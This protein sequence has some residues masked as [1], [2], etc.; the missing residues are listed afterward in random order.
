VDPAERSRVLAQLQRRLQAALQPLLQ[1]MFDALD[2]R[3]FDLAERS[4]VASQ[5]QVFFEG[6]RECRRKRN[7]IEHDFL[8]GVADAVRPLRAYSPT[9]PATLTLVGNEE[10]EETLTLSGMADRAAARMPHAVDALDLRL[11]RLLEQPADPN[12]PGRLSPQAMGKTFRAACQRLDVG[13]EVRLVAYNAFGQHVLE[14]LEP[15]YADLNRELVAA[16]VLPAIAVTPPRPAVLPLRPPVAHEPQPPA[17]AAPRPRGRVPAAPAYAGTPP[18]EARR[19]ADAQQ[20]LL[21]ELRG[22]IRPATQGSPDL[23]AA[24]Q[25]ADHALRA[26]SD[27]VS[28]LSSQLVLSAL[29]SLGDFDESPTHLKSQL[30]ETSRRLGG[31]PRARLQQHDEDTVDL[32]GMV[33]DYVRQDPM[34]PKPLQ[35]LLTRLQ[36]PFLKAALSDPE[37]MKA[38]DHPA[39]RLMDDL[40]E[41]AIGWCPSIDPEKQV[42]QRVSALVDSLVQP[43]DAARAPFEHALEEL[44]DFLET[45]RHRAEL[46]EQRAVEAALGRERLRIARSRVAS[47]LERRLGRYTPLPWIRQVLRGPWANY[48]VLLWLRHGESGEGFREALR[49]ADELLW[50]DEHGAN[51]QDDARLRLDEDALEEQL[52][53]GLSTVAYHDREI[54]RL[55]GELRQFIG[56]LRRRR[57]APPFL[58]EI[59]PKLGTADFSH[60]WAEAETQEQPE[61]AEVDAELLG[62]LRALLPG[63]WFEFG[64]EGAAERAKLSWTSPFSGRQLFVNRNGLRV[65]ERSPEQLA[66]EIE[67]GMARMLETSR[68][69]QRALQAL[70][71]RLRPQAMPRRA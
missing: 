24:A 55:A 41:F 53:A 40:G 2:A 57:P 64:S 13:I 46:A 18:Q 62:K 52:R 34:L 4:R 22:L 9:V 11:G 28:A 6:L 33:F 25:A 49:F 5:Q 67:K 1:A 17:P 54:E 70:V 23:A 43:R 26:A 59:D 63:A 12:A 16:G 3:L 32:V 58:Y 15:I 48:L 10:L 66:E 8:E 35:A 61:A 44:R 65:G 7:D 38:S 51:S 30:M 29:D 50:C 69:L 36:V 31:D 37:L 21:Q 45:G 47:M 68:L 60:H 14:A 42:L 27:A 20:G 71:T 19:Q 56:S 39:R